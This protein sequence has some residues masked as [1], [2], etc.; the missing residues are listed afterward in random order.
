[1]AES[2][3]V[4]PAVDTKKIG[5]VELEFAFQIAMQFDAPVAT[6]TPHGT[7]LYQGIAGGK[8]SGPKLTG[9]VYRGSGGEYGLRRADNV[10]DLETHFMVRDERGEWIYFEHGGYHRNADGYYR[11][12]VYTDAESGGQYG[13]MNDTVM[14]ATGR[15]APDQKEILFSYYIAK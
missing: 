15:V 4:P 12:M 13:W 14:I 10:D 2:K 3:F 9:T 6:E 8:V 11:A 5:K 1:M 7:R